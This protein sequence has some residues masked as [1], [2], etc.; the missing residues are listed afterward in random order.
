MK[1]VELADAIESMSHYA[2]D[3]GDEMI[4]LTRNQDPVAALVSL[5]NVDRESLVLST[6]AEF[7]AIIERARAECA[8]GRTLSL[9]A[10]KQAVMPKRKKAG[11]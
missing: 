6:N 4:V 3:L 10:M 11:R 8:A 7:L 2:N 9:E 5:K 1:T